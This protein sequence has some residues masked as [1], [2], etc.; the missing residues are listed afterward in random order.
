MSCAIEGQLIPTDLIKLIVVDL[1]IEDRLFTVPRVCHF[2][3][4][5]LSSQAVFFEAAK[6]LLSDKISLYRWD[7]NKVNAIIKIAK[8]NHLIKQI[9]KKNFAFDSYYT[10]IV[11]MTFRHGQNDIVLKGKSLACEAKSQ[12][13][14][15]NWNPSTLKLSMHKSK[16]G[17]FCCLYNFN[18]FVKKWTCEEKV[19]YFLK[20]DAESSWT[21]EEKGFIFN[22]YVNCTEIRPLEMDILIREV[23]CLEARAYVFYFI[24]LNSLLLSEMNLKSLKCQS[25]FVYGFDKNGRITKYVEGKEAKF[26]LK[27][28]IES[29]KEILVLTWQSNDDMR[30]HRKMSDFLRWS[31]IVMSGTKL[32]KKFGMPF[33]QK[34]PPTQPVIPMLNL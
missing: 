24:Y 7:D 2:W 13:F 31:I 25:E 22:E 17:D 1:S 12:S 34:H 30:K 20:I 5:I 6:I 21:V 8:E 16:W 28:K 19:A 3:S 4:T 23:L 15:I 27:M 14:K 18:T 10:R 32:A 29:I 11:P 33:M 9:K 26:K